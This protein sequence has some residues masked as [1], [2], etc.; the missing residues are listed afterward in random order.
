MRRALF[1]LLFVLILVPG[2][3]AAHC[4]IPC[5]IYG[6]AMR[7]EMLREHATT[8]DKSMQQVTALSAE[9]EKNY[10][11]IVRWVMNKETHAEEFQ[12]IVSQYFMHQRVKPAEVENAAYVKKISV[13]HEML[14]TAMK[15]KQTTDPANAARLFE[16]IDEFSEA[17]FTPEQL[18]H[19]RDHR[20]HEGE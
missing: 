7:I 12:Q 18:Q 10:N 13:L 2:L 9:G 5:G 8:I 19:I 15:C 16:L 6:D 20:L 14:V 17:Y 4:E 11:Q 1:S 3:A